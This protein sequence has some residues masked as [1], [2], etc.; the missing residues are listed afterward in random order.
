MEPGVPARGVR[1]PGHAAPRPARLRPARGRRRGEG[2]RPA[3]RGLRADRRGRDA[4]GGHRLRDRR[5]GEDRGE[6][7]PGHEDLLHQRDGGAVRG[8][9]R[10]REAAG[11]RDRL[12][13]PDRPE[14]PQRRPRVRWWLPAQ[15]HPGVHGPGRGARGGPGADLPA[16][17]RQ[18]QH[19][20]PD[21]DGGAGPRG[22]RRQ[23][24]RQA[25]RGARCGVQ[26]E[27]RRHPRLAGA[28]R[29]RAAAAAGR[30]GA[31]DGSG[32]G[33]ELPPD[34]AAAG[35]R[36][37]A[38]GGGGAGGSGAAP[39]RVGAVP[40]AGP[41]GVRPR[42]VAE[43][44]ARRAQRAR[45]GPLGGRRL[46][47]PGA[48]TA[49]LCPESATGAAPPGPPAGSGS[50]RESVLPPRSG[51]WPCG[52]ARPRTACPGT[53]RSSAA[54]CRRCRAGRPRRTAAS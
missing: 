8:H 49:E 30:D 2:A 14:V 46:E 45:S 54:P 22:L 6:L 11:R 19:A 16:R 48:G 35:L 43:A 29:R 17:G 39:H 44:G 53:P 36:G 18:H 5:D 24:A 26:A 9:R 23:P 37:L 3:R 25:D 28:E 12:R 20:P 34:V 42:R 41:R 4:E 7:V 38:R 13:R 27:Q 40:Q 52:T 31:G 33:G 47:L 51:P 1:R 21:P 10:G 15:G 50:P 32:G